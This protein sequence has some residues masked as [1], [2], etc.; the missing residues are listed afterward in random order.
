ME[1]TA[2]CIIVADNDEKEGVKLWRVNMKVLAAIDHKD[3]EGYISC[4]PG[5]SS[6]DVVRDKREL[7]ERSASLDYDLLLLSRKLPGNEDMEKLIEALT[8]KNV[9]IRRYA[10]LYGEADDYCDDFVR[11]LISL[12]VYDFHVGDEVTSK[13]I[14]RLVFR[15][16]SRNTALGYLSSGY[17]D[18]AY[19]NSPPLYKAGAFSKGLKQLFG[20]GE[21]RRPVFSNLVIS[22]ISGHT[23]GKSHT[24]WNL[25][26]CLSGHRYATSLLN[27]DRGYSANNYFNID[28]I[29]YDLLDFTIRNN[30]HKGILENCCKRKSLNLISGRLGDEN[31]ITEDDFIKLLYSIRTKSDVTII[32]TRTGL[33][34]LAR[35]SVRNS[36][37]DLVIFDCDLLHFH[38][39]MKM[40]EELRDDFI[41][42]KAIAVI[43]NTDIRSKAHKLIYNRLVDTVIP[44]RDI[45]FISSCGL[46]GNEA[47][48][49]G[50]S[51]YNTAAEGSKEFRNDIDRL[52]DKLSGRNG[53]EGHIAGRY[54]I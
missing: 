30:S 36:A 4:L 45:T 15:P 28:E 10:F 53:R 32:D 19:F 21:I 29:Y 46:S 26:C 38:M 6:L 16:G 39:T 1:I 7:M 37:F 17:N 34:P 51:P 27:I 13:D 23:T 52:V 11:L 5:I 41:P 25:A 44:F 33:S 22:I 35:Q 43:N 24:A 12:G 9:C 54:D 42:E 8:G 2:T 48:L 40:L 14:E 50:S 49:Q 3:I 47:V 31:E 20:R 18:Q